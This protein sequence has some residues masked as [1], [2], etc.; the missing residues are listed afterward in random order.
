MVCYGL[1]SYIVVLVIEEA[2][3]FVACFVFCVQLFVSC[4]L[5]DVCV[6]WFLLLDLGCLLL[7]LVD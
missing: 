2:W 6:S 7:L 4:M 1:L 3:L 5:I